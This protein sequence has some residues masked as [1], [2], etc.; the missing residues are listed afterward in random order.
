MKLINSRTPNSLRVSAFL[1]EKGIELPVETVDV[2]GGGTRTPEFLAINS[3]G[4]VPVLQLDDGT[5]LSESVAICRYLEECFPEP[6][7]F[8][9]TAQERAVTEMWNRRMERHLF[10][11]IAAMARHSFPFFADK[12]EQ[13]PA[14]AQSAA[15]EFDRNWAWL[16]LELADGR[17]FI[18]GDRFSVADITGMAMLM[19]CDVANRPTPEDA[20]H[21]KRWENSIRSRASFAASRPQAA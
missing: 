14:Y 20:I 16:D 3:L 18:A 1:A 7:L 8:G 11:T 4:E 13:I 19:V 21:A 15:K 6:S 9:K 5:Y 10:D 17:S 12:L 2:L